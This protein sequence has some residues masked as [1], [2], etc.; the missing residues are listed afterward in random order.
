MFCFCS[1]LL[2]N[3]F[4]NYAFKK[5]MYSVTQNEIKHPDVLELKWGDKNL[6][7]FVLCFW[8]GA[9]MISKSS[10]LTI[11]AWLWFSCPQLELPVEY[12]GGHFYHLKFCFLPG[13]HVFF[14]SVEMH[15]MF[16]SSS[17]RR[18][19]YILYYRHLNGWL[20]ISCLYKL[21]IAAFI[22]FEACCVDIKS[23]WNVWRL[24]LHYFQGV[25]FSS[26][27]C[28]WP[29]HVCFCLSVPRRHVLKMSQTTTSAQGVQR[30]VLVTQ[31]PT[32][33]LP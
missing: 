25:D 32:R 1:D 28:M 21:F 5:A 4:L 9:R 23:P 24:W 29:S 20:E 19:L 26:Q 6:V 17:R 33:V 13:R 16:R 3:V 14:L 10:A 15:L 7:S 2:N 11:N 31:N 12:S 18:W 27:S 30:K 22:W 8:L